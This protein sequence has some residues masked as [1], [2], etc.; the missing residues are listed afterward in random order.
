M[1]P[2]NDPYRQ[3]QDGFPAPHRFIPAAILIG[4]GILFLLDN[5]N[6]FPIEQITKFW[7]ILLIALGLFLLVDR[8]VLKFGPGRYGREEYP[9]ATGPGYRIREAAVFGGGKRRINSQEFVGGKVDAV[10]GGFEIDL[11][12]AA[13]LNDTA[14][15]DINVV[16]GGTEVKI[17]ESWSAIVHGTGAFGA[18]SDNSRQ[19]DPLRYPNPKRL[20]VRGGAVFGHVEVRN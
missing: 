16:F 17:P 20:I 8:T 14:T 6:I 7:P 2:V 10:F 19:P 1:Q 3:R 5:L 9:G 12:N 4:L 13:M 15:M 11:R 18:F